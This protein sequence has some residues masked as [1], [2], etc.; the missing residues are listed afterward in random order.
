MGKRGV[1]LHIEFTKKNGKVTSYWETAPADFDQLGSR[2]MEW[3]RRAAIRHSPGAT[4]IKF[5]GRD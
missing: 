4:N 3:I 1:R 2:R 5:L